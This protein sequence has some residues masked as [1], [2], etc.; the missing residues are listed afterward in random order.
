[1]TIATVNGTKITREELDAQLMQLSQNPNIPTPKPEEE[2]KYKQFEEMV[3]QQ[4]VNDALIYTKAKENG[5]SVSEEDVE[6]EY[7]VIKAKFPN[8]EEFA[9]QL[10]LMKL[11]ESILKDTIRKQ[12]TIDQHY[13]ELFKDKDLTASD[14]EARTLYDTHLQDKDNMPKFEEIKEQIKQE[15][16]Q[17]K[18]HQHL[19]THIQELRKDADIQISL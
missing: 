8:E 14:V 4:L 10:E 7:D 1:M 19:A 2:E 11:S 13:K 6:K 15:L 5:H 12:R 18:M 17:Q 3:A 16:G 9:K